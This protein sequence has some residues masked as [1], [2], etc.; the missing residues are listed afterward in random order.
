MSSFASDFSDPFF[1][2]DWAMAPLGFG[3]FNT[4]VGFPID[5]T[6]PGAALVPNLGLGGSRVPKMDITET[7]EHYRIQCDLPGLQKKDV[8]ISANDNVITITG[9]RRSDHDINEV[10]HIVE[11]KIGRFRRSIRMPDDAKVDEGLKAKLENG[12]L[13]MVIMKKNVGLTGNQSAKSEKKI[14]IQ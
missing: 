13:N 14:N 5:T 1:A 7:D 9:R 8:N 10:H 4:S 11:R 2:N 12:V 3:G 6:S